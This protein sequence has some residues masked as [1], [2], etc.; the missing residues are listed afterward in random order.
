MRVTRF[1]FI[2][3][4][5]FSALFLTQLSG[6]EIPRSIIFIIAEVRLWAADPV[7]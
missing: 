5:A 3:I 1:R 6:Q 7:T 4:L 2:C